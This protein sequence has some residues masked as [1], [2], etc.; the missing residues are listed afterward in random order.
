MENYSNS[1]TVRVA[2]GDR[3]YRLDVV[4]GCDGKE[5]PS[6]YTLC[7]GPVPLAV[8]HNTH[9]GGWEWVEGGFMHQPAEYIGKSIEE[10]LISNS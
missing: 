5:L 3:N 4:V 9:D 8:I 10:L 2:I 7:E 1:F 6:Y